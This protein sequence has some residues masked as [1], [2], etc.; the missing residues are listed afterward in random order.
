MNS[1]LEGVAY[2]LLGLSISIIIFSL[3]MLIRN[4]LV[5]DYRMKLIGK[6]RLFLNNAIKNG[7]DV[8]DEDFYYKKL[9]SYDTILFRFWV[10]PL[11]KFLKK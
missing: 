1:F 4:I 8:K 6:D 9:P 10:W 5:H 3:Y 2:Q 7:L 11:S